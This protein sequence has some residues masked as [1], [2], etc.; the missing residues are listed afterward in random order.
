VRGEVSTETFARPTVRRHAANS[1]P[2]RRTRRSHRPA[3]AESQI[4][5]WFAHATT[6]LRYTSNGPRALTRRT[7]RKKT[8]PHT[9]ENNQARS[10]EHLGL[11]V[12][13]QNDRNRSHRTFRLFTTCRSRAKHG[14]GM[15]APFTAQ[16]DMELPARQGCANARPRRE[17]ACYLMAS[18]PARHYDSARGLQFVPHLDRAAQQSGHRMWLTDARQAAGAR[19]ATTARLG[20]GCPHG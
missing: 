5:P 17:I 8:K 16:P 3:V 14:A 6:T 19:D 7:M 13:D 15:S 2:P 18:A 9:R 1:R 4:E 20:H 10:S 11:I 12:N